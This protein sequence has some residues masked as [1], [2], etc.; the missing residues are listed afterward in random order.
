MTR[1]GATRRVAPTG[2]ECTL[3]N[4]FNCAVYAVITVLSLL[5]WCAPA[6]AANDDSARELLLTRLPELA[7]IILCLLALG[8][9]A[10]W[11][12]RG[13]IPRLRSLPPL[14]AIGDAIGRATEQGSPVIYITGWGGDMA[15]PTTMASMV[16][17]SEV[18]QRTAGYNC[19]LL[20]PSHDP[21][22][23][24]V[25]QETVSQ[26]AIAAGRPDWYR[27]DD[28]AFVSQS[29][30]GYAAAVDGLMVRE[31]PGA[32]FLLGTF[33]GEAL[34]LAE[35]AHQSGAVTIAGTDSTI[36]L[37]FLLVACDYTLIGEELF[38]ASGLVSGDRTIAGAVLAQ[39]WLKYVIMSLLVIGAA[40]LAV[41][42]VDISGWFA[43]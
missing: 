7:G 9:A 17:L 14:D 15:R 11:I 35:T 6:C 42:G 21:L 30:L 31:R 13:G 20:F 24:S 1:P 10:I 41:G 32:V 5:S 3:E 8:A 38:A 25:A 37:S 18:A 40:L 39:D 2:A 34:I 16:V 33:E 36:Q 23:A 22:V 12:R 26:A 28:I 4:Q 29:Q 27:P 19:R 43:R